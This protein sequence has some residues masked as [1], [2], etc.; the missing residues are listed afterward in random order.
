MTENKNLKP[1][2]EPMFA[3]YDPPWTLPFMRRNEVMLRVA[4]D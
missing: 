4:Q 1:A 2:G 3:Y